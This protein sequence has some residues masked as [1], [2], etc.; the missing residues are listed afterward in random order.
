MLDVST[1]KRS[2]SGVIF[3]LPCHVQLPAE[4]AEDFERTGPA[5][6]RPDDLRSSPRFYCQ[7]KSHVG[8]IEYRQSLPAIARTSAWH[9][10]YTVD[11]SRGG[12]GLL[13]SEQLFPGEQVRLLLANNK[14][15]TIEI[16]WCRR[17]GEKCYRLGAQ[18]V[19]GQV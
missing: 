5:P 11:I 16:V 14:S 1:E 3:Q 18:F 7:G 15:F 4:L 10:V 2:L 19:K 17:L 9:R 12:I 13:H 6:S 8:A